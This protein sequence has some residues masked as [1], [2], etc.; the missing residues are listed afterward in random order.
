[1]TI[2]MMMMIMIDDY[3]P[4]NLQRWLWRL[5]MIV[6]LNSD[7]VNNNVVVVV[8][9]VVVVVVDVVVDN[10]YNNDVENN[11]VADHHD[12]DYSSPIN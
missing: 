12:D 4:I 11:F 1:M 3:S 6:F 5:I 10:S 2:L 9:V 8:I 7:Y